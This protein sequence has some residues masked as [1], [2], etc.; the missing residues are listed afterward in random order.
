MRH[1]FFAG[2]SAALV[3]LGL[4]AGCDTA[5]FDPLG[6]SASR[7]AVS[8]TKEVNMASPEELVGSWT[9]RELNPYPDQPAVSTT[10]ILDAD[11]TVR[12]RALLPMAAEVPGATDMIMTMT[13]S[14]KVEGDRLVTSDT[15]VEMTAADGST[16]G[17]SAMMN[18][19][20]ASFM[21]RAGDSTAEI[22][23]VTA[24]ELVMRGDEA[25]A[26]TVACL[27]EA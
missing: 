24:T 2:P 23:K 5:G 20:A 4:L 13:G 21:D 6:T 8:V 22:F 3:A 11:G 25:D 7:P 9:C 14:W 12:S 16:G 27:R 26:A 10:L 15:D 1:V 19:I 17:M 18:S